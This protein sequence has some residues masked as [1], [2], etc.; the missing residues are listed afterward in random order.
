M[1][2]DPNLLSGYVQQEVKQARGEVARK[3]EETVNA[4]QVVISD[5]SALY[6]MI[7]VENT[8]AAESRV[9]D[10]MT[11]FEM[12]GQIRAQMA[13]NSGNSLEVHSNL[14]SE[15]IANLI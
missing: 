11:A 12:M 9:E 4:S 5:R 10:T 7:E 1:K 2:I 13:G 14:T 15:R 8:A 6:R 3:E